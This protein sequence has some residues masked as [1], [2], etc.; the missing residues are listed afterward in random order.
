MENRFFKLPFW[1]DEQ[2]LLRDLATCTAWQW[3][4][5]FNQADYAGEWTSIALRSSSGH[6]TDIYAHPDR[7]AYHDTPL[8]EQCPYFRQLLAMF[9]CEK[10]SVRLLSLAPGSS[11][12]THRDLQAAYEYGMF[13]LHIPLQTSDSVSFIVDGAALD[14]KAGECWYANF[15]LPHSVQNNG[16]SHR[17]HLVV[18][19][20]RNAWSDTIFGKAGYDHEAERRNLDHDRHTKQQMIAELSL[21]DTEASK[22]LVSQLKAE[23]GTEP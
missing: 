12:N 4:A 20:L 2:L 8:L 19:G 18:D 9:E 17:I 7:E 3:K 1:F 16:A 15:H 5:H 13:R 22:K 21:M 11:I 6:E 10:E 14:M 23:L